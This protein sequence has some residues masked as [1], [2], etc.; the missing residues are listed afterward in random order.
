[1]RYGCDKN[2]HF[3]YLLISFEVVCLSISKMTGCL[4]AGLIKRG[5]EIFVLGL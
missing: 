3:T 2:L 5:T 1:M 4:I